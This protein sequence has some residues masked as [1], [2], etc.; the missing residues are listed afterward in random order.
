MS[1]PENDPLYVTRSIAPPV[2]EYA[3]CVDR[4]FSSRYFTNNG[5]F[6]RTLE[7]GLE[8]RLGVPHVA[9]CANGTL[10]LQLGLHAAGLAGRQ[11]ITTPFSY[12]ASLS[13][14]LWEGCEVI[15][16]DIDEETCCLDPQC[17][18]DRMTED[19]AGI[20]AVHIY[21]N[22]CDVEAFEALGQST[23]VP[24]LYDAA[25]AFGSFYR[26]KSALAY[27]DFATCSTH[28][29]KVF[30]TVEGG[31]FV[32]HTQKA[33]DTFSLMRACGHVGDRHILPGINAKLSELHAAMGCCLLDRYT[34]NIAARKH[35]SQ[36]YDSLLPSGGL[37]RP[38]LRHGLDWNYGYYPVIFD[39]QGALQRALKRMNELNIYPRRYFYPALNT[40]A[41]L[42]H[43]DSCPVA[44][45][46][47]LRALCLPLY[48]E[49]EE[50]DV[51][52]IAGIIRQSL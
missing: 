25:Q 23:G 20:L 46:L 31:F 41:Y 47:S 22:V 16:A 29:T 6:V 27:G 34:E 17:V 32:C 24:I 39:T 2:E 28:A 49:L 5:E 12:V 33:F 38:T 11:V 51:E 4:I 9:T 44:E 10:A 52:R 14:L 26:G 50:R 48:A 3:V 15:F 36:M 13:A 8:K 42:R 19:T 43:T 1:P 30:H 21:G 7:Q 45:S 35:V 37:R 40:L 18:A